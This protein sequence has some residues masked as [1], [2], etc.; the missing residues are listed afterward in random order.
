MTL[1]D[2]V[3]VDELLDRNQLGE[4]VLILALGF[5]G[6]TLEWAGLHQGRNRRAEKQLTQWPPG[7]RKIG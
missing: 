3:A 5:K 1:S 7:S 2:F 4:G 6:F